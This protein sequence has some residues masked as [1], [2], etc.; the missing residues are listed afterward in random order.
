ME[1]GPGGFAAV[2]SIYDIRSNWGVSA[3]DIPNYLS[4]SILYE[5]PAG[6]G[7]PYLNHGPLSEILG[8]WQV[9]TITA[10]RSGQPYN[11]DVLGDVANVGNTIGYWTYARPNLIGNPNVSNP[12][13][14]EYFNPAAFSI[15]V[16]SFGNFGKNALR[17]AGVYN[18]D[19]S[20]FKIFPIKE[21]VQLEFRAEAFNIFNI[22]N[23]A[24]PGVDIGTADAGVVT[25]VAVPPR[26]IQLGMK[27][28]F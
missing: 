28:R 25:A 3:Y 19:F 26:Q 13:A 27:L 15:P 9:N 24:P 11:L 12:T 4:A 10:L 17:S 16:A 8:G 5:L 23:L 21:T 18:V 2:Q 14:A 20:L 6:K 22:Q 1:N 7:K